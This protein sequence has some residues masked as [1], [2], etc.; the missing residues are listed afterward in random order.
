MAVNQRT[1]KLVFDAEATVNEGVESLLASIGNAKTVGVMIENSGANSIDVEMYVN[2]NT[3]Q[4]GG[5]NSIDQT[6]WYKFDDIATVAAGATTAIAFPDFPFN[7]I[8]LVATPTVADGQGEIT[9]KVV[10]VH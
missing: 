10:W 3:S 6:E 8:Q 1:G 9:A 7:L 5:H 2:A 4:A